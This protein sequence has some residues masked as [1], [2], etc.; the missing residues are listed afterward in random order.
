MGR[1]RTTVLFVMVAFG[2]LLCGGLISWRLRSGT[3]K[4]SGLSA[5]D[6]REVRAAVQAAQVQ[7]AGREFNPRTRF[8]QQHPFRALTS[9]TIRSISRLDAS[10][11]C[12]RMQDVWNSHIGYTYYVESR[13]NGWTVKANAWEGYSEPRD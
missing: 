3:C 1:Q 2:A 4:I 6:E 8:P 12:V 9:G 10:N 13:T 11:A 7:I 5:R